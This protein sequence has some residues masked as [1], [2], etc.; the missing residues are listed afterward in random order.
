MYAINFGSA[1][2]IEALFLSTDDPRFLWLRH[3]YLKDFEDWFGTIEVR[4]I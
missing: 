2:K 4:C 1:T 3:P